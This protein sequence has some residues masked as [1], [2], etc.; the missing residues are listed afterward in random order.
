M[1]QFIK[2]NPKRVSK[3]F[4]IVH[5]FLCSFNGIRR[6]CTTYERVCSFPGRADVPGYICRN[7]YPK[8]ESFWHTLTTLCT[9]F[10]LRHPQPQQPQIITPQPANTGMKRI[11]QD[12]SCCMVLPSSSRRRCLSLNHRAAAPF[13]VVP[14]VL[15][16][17]LRHHC[18]PWGNECSRWLLCHPQICHDF[19]VSCDGQIA[20]IPPCQSASPHLKFLS[21]FPCI[22]NPNLDDCG[23]M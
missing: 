13:I 14:L 12:A 21:R 9:R 7:D 3:L 6:L 19:F 17:S 2:L 1:V 4:L 22:G 10:F 15:L 5:S 8:K 18:L 11:C 23:V 20:A 16:S